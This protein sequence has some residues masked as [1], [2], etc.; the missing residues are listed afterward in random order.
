LEKICHGYYWIAEEGLEKPTDYKCIE[1]CLSNPRAVVCM[2]SALFYQGM[3]KKE[4]EYLSV[5]T[6]RT[7]RSL[8]MMNFPVKR[9]YFSENYFQAGV[10]KIDTEFG[11]YNIYD[12]ERSVCDIYRL[13]AEMNLEIVNG[14]RNNEQQ[15]KRLKQY[16]ELLRIKNIF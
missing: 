6:E 5:A 8:L 1:L 13:E 16:E 7:D 2:E 4:P 10:R 9:H 3:I 15:Y 14:I 11:C 12:I